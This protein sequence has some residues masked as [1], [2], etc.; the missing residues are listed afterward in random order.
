[1]IKKY[2]MEK[3]AMEETASV[4]PAGSP[5]VKRKTNATTNALS[6][7]LLTAVMAVILSAASVAH[8]GLEQPLSPSVTSTST[9]PFEQ[10]H[11][12]LQPMG[13]ALFSFTSG[14]SAPAINY[15]MGTVRL[16]VMLNDVQFSGFFRGNCELLGEAFG[17][18]IFNGPGD[19]LGGGSILIRYNY[20]QPNSHFVP[21]FQIG[22]GGLYIDSYK[23]ES[24]RVIG[25]GFEFNLQGAV[26]VRYMI[27][28]QW[29]A[30]LEA[31][32]RHISNAGLAP[33]NDGLNSIGPFVGVSYFY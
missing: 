11:M 21:Y 12:E 19:V 25:Q 27:N 3:S 8:A 30:V 2:L 32:Y 33:R 1:M 20:V 31:D 4:S 15:A 6:S 22:G 13:A 5:W 24:Q 18:G 29:A 26:G 7:L 14:A 23:D 28:D 16:G 9:S 17:G 10:W